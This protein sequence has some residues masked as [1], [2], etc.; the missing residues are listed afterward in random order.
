MA[1]YANYQV[2]RNKHKNAIGV[3]DKKRNFNKKNDN[4]TKSEKLMQ[5]IAAWASFYISR[6]DI[7]AEEYL[8]ITLKPFQKVLLYCMMHYNYTAFFASRGLGR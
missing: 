5:G 3:F 2:K 8:G 1:S 6:P 7:F 4:V